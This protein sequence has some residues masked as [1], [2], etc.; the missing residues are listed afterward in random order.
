MDRFTLA[1]AITPPYVNIL[2]LADAYRRLR[3]TG[4]AEYTV[5]LWKMTLN[6]ISV[7]IYAGINTAVNLKVYRNPSFYDL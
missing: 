2:I 5:S 1:Y 4:G 6:F 3:K 7:I